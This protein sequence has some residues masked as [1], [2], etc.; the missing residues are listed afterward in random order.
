M[1]IVQ[2]PHEDIS[3]CQW[4]IATSIAGD[5]AGIATLVPFVGSM[6]PSEKSRAAGAPVAVDISRLPP[7]AMITVAWRRVPVFLVNRTPAMLEAVVL[8][9]SMVADPSTERPFSMPLPDYC[10][11]EYRSRIDHRNLLV[12]VGVC[13]HLACTPRPRF[14][15]GPQTNLPDNWPGGFL[16]PC[17]GSMYDLAGRVFKN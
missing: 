2:W 5:I 15:P 1:E 3:R 11:N 7:G 12:V 9:H 8:A 14:E 17:R 13:M 4:L 10:R 16:C 6:A